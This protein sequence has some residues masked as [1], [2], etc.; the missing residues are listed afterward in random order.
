MKNIPLNYHIMEILENL[1]RSTT[2]YVFT[3]RGKPIRNVG[4]LKKSFETACRDAAIPFGR[5]IQ[6]GVSFHDIRRTRTRVID[7]AIEYEIVGRSPDE[8]ISS[9]PYL[10]LPQIHDALSFYYENRAELD[11]KLEQDQKFIM[12]LKSKLTSKII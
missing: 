3:F 7:I 1:P 6:N 5:K 9:H 12:Q 8:I 10:N 11:Q 2:G 4:G